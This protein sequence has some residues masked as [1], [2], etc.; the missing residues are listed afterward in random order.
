M[1]D[2]PYTRSEMSRRYYELSPE[3][4]HKVNQEV[5][6]RFRKETGVNRQ[7]DWN[8]PE[9]R[10]L[11][12]RW[13]RIRD[14]VVEE[15]STK[16]NT[17]TMDLS[18][19]TIEV[20]LR[21]ADNKINLPPPHSELTQAIVDKFSEIDKDKDAFL[22]K[23]EIDK[24]LQDPNISK[25]SKHGA[26]V[27][28]LKKHLAD[29]VR[30]ISS[31]DE[32]VWASLYGNKRPEAITRADVTAYDRLR[33]KNPQ[34]SGI[35]LTENAYY[36]AKD[37]IETIESIDYKLFTSTVDPS[38]VKQAEI[39]DCWLL[40][41]IVG[42]ALRLEGGEIRGMIQPLE[43]DRFS[44]FF[45]GLTKQGRPPITVSK[46]TDGE[47]GI[48]SSAGANG[49]WLTV[50]EKAYGASVNRDAVEK[51]EFDAADVGHW[52]EEGI[53]LVT[54]NSVDTD[55]LYLTSK[56]KTRT[57]LQQAF[58]KNKV[59]TALI[60]RAFF[61]G[62]LLQYRSNGLPMGHQYTVLGFDASNDV[63]RLRNPWGNNPWDT[64]G[65]PHPS[66]TSIGRGMFEMSLDD[67]DKYFSEISYE[68]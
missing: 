56:K 14:K 11:A 44:V 7:L 37:K 50:L 33:L 8:A 60:R 12:R 16:G 38:Q 46:P 26:M 64:E 20:D 24:A 61:G 17:R 4:R 35:R 58:E 54:G 55:K 48:F 28:T 68:E 13:L 10:P 18:P 66:I 5:D 62:E 57:K 63:I 21:S 19:M 51:T 32:G 6:Q 43:G 47:I 1:N 22:S 45:P 41:A 49:L 40:A 42:T 23:Q 31:R 2:K 29:L 67:F 52:G 3:G 27:A 30:A 65:K 53:E 15:E 34:D 25:G 36:Y 39:G 9:D 59:V